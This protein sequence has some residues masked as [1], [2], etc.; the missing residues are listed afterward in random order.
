MTDELEDDPSLLGLRRRPPN[1][2]ESLYSRNRK[3]SL[4]T[5]DR[6]VGEIS[7]TLRQLD[8]I[9]A[10]RDDINRKANLLQT[11]ISLLNLPSSYDLRQLRKIMPARPSGQKNND[12]WAWCT[13][14]AAE[15][16]VLTIAND[17]KTEIEF[18]IQDIISCSDAGTANSGGH[19]AFNYITESHIHL[20]DDY[21]YRGSDLP[22]KDPDSRKYKAEGWGYLE[23]GQNG[24]PA[25]ED[26]KSKVIQ[27]GALYV[28]IH[29]TGALQD[30]D[31]K[32]PDDVFKQNT[33]PKLG[34]TNHAVALCGWDDSKG[35]W[36]IKNS[37]GGGWGY[38][39]FG[40]VGY[41]QNSITYAAAWV[42][43]KPAPIS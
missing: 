34:T 18:S 23:R 36:L 8:T 25:R 37:W 39:G 35:A 19:N 31:N 10:K 12:C 3:R 1:Y 38:E 2:A 27:Y 6:L 28:A 32:G 17:Q 26:V 4:H 22:C 24:F 30:W 16:S 13:A 42:K 33:T 40:W 15:S 5:S 14:A 43:M 7:P 21:P 29:A 41:D 9:T 11:R 20:E